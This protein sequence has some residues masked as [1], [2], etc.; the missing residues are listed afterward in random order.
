MGRVSS[1]ASQKRSRTKREHHYELKFK[2]ALHSIRSGRFTVLQAA[3]EYHI[4]VSTLRDRFHGAK[5]RRAAH[6]H[7]QL[8]SDSEEQILVTWAI[9]LASFNLPIRTDFMVFMALKIARR[10]DPTRTSI[11]KNWLTGFLNRHPEIKTKLSR[12]MDRQ[13]KRQ[14]DP[15]IINDFYRKLYYLI[16][17]YGPFDPE[18]VL[19]FDEKGFLLGQGT[20][21]RV[22]VSTMTKEAHQLQDGSREFVTVV[23][24]ILAN[25]VVLPPYIILKGKQLTMG[26]YQGTSKQYSS[27]N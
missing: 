15:K 14:E 2:Q 20:R 24:V 25:G 16:N 27:I 3:D 9:K 23:E 21:Q 8:L 1:K 4:P 13:R 18:Y 10:R 26:H 19:N 17:K 12:R 22:I 5:G 11:G 7:Q 6:A